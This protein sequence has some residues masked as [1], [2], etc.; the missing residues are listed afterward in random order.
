MASYEVIPASMATMAKVSRAGRG[1]RLPLAA[2][3][4]GRPSSSS[5][6]ETSASMPGPLC[7]VH[8]GVSTTANDLN[9]K[10]GLQLGQEETTLPRLVG[11]R[12]LAGQ[13]GALGGQAV[14]QG[15]EARPGLALESLRPGALLGIAAVDLG[16]VGSRHG[17]G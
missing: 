4:S 14:L 17:G 10:G 3:G 6:K 8:Q 12:I 5:I 13:D 2:R 11:L 16:P 7:D 15:I 9:Q 1:C